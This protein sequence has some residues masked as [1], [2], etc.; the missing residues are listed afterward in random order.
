MRAKGHVLAALARLITAAILALVSAAA[1]L[2]GVGES[3]HDTD[4]GKQVAHEGR[5]VFRS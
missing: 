4:S 1:G 2:A 3:A 5:V